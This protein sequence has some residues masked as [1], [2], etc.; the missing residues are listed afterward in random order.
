MTALEKANTGVVTN[1][2]DS[3]STQQTIERRELSRTQISQEVAK[4][5]RDWRLHTIQPDNN[6]QLTRPIQQPNAKHI[7]WEETLI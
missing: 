3:K 2:K 6:F 4:F 5:F 7:I 1:T